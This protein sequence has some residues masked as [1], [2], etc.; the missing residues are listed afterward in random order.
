MC[1]TRV[2]IALVSTRLSLVCEDGLRDNLAG[3]E[4]SHCLLAFDVAS[5]SSR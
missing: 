1:S 5:D 3:Y 4:T 2:V